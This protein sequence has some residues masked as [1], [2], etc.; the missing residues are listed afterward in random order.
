MG[1]GNAVERRRK[2]GNGGVFLLPEGHHLVSTCHPQHP[3]STPASHST[4]LPHQHP[5]APCIHTPVTAN[6]A[7]C[8]SPARHRCRH[9]RAPHE[10]EA[11]PA[12]VR[13]GNLQSHGAV[14]PVIW[15]GFFFWGGGGGNRGRNAKSI[16]ESVR[17]NTLVA[18]YS[19]LTITSTGTLI[20]NLSISRVVC[21]QGVRVPGPYS[22]VVGWMPRGRG[23]SSPASPQAPGQRR[24]H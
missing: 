2:E 19:G 20:V 5:T 24:A 10:D 11:E 12:R 8:D 23:Q 13:L 17:V 21:M 22:S 18:L 3:A 16:K 4:L 7:K 9:V 15:P 1:M 14:V 6:V